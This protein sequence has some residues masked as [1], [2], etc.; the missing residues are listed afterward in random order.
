LVFVGVVG[1]V[2]GV[3]LGFGFCFI[4][5]AQHHYYQHY[6]HEE[7]EKKRRLLLLGGGLANN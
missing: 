5:A 6:H 3:V 4:D 1:V 2:F 7:E